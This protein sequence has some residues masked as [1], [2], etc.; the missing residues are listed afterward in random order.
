MKKSDEKKLKQPVFI[1][2]CAA[3]VTPC[4]SLVTPCGSP[5][6]SL[7]RAARASALRPGQP[8][9]PPPALAVAMTGRI[10]VAFEA[11]EHVVALG[12]A[13]LLRDHGRVVRAPAAAAD[14]HHRHVL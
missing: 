6:R 8:R 14:E 10:L 3:L 1:T 7:T 12:I 13:R 9:M 4:A 11:L 2:P 5:G